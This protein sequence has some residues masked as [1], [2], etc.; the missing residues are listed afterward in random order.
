MTAMKKTTKTL[1]VLLT[2]IVALSAVTVLAV[3]PANAQSTPKPSVPQFTVKFIQAYYPVD[4]YPP[5]GATELTIQNQPFT[6][7]DNMT[8]VFYGLRLKG[9]NDANWIDVYNIT[10]VWEH[11]LYPANASSQTTVLVLPQWG[12]WTYG[13][14]DFQVE[15]VIASS[16]YGGP[17]TYEGISDWSPTQTVTVP[18]YSIPS[19]SITPSS[20]ASSSLLTS[21]LL[22]IVA[23]ALVVIAILL[24][25]IVVLLLLV[26]HRKTRT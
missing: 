2:I 19:A 22:I 16:P 6:P 1:T 17:W 23:I 7:P 12:F 20:P 18:K 13:E 10:S 15:A 3:K 5:E 11:N 21:I 25:V 9:H 14:V 26:R 4:G 24:G 8:N